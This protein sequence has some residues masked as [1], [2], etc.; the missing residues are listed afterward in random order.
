[1]PKVLMALNVPPSHLH[2]FSSK[3]HLQYTMH[4]FIY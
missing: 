4:D 3:F 1:L 2:E